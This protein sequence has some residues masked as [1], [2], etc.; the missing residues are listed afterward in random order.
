MAQL[1]LGLGM[2]RHCRL[3][4]LLADVSLDFAWHGGGGG[5]SFAIPASKGEE[6]VSQR[7]G[8]TLPLDV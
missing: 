7:A 3:T 5:L 4:S 1:Q 6:G 2:I 8:Q